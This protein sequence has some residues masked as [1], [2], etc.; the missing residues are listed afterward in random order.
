M[1]TLHTHPQTH[2]ASGSSEAAHCVWHCESTRGTC[3]ELQ[4]PPSPASK[5]TKKFSVVIIHARCYIT[6]IFLIQCVCVCA[7]LF[8]AREEVEQSTHRVFNCFR[9]IHSRLILFSKFTMEFQSCAMNLV[10]MWCGVS[11]TRRRGAYVQFVGTHR[12]D[13]RLSWQDV[14]SFRTKSNALL[15]TTLN[16]TCVCVCSVHCVRRRKQFTFRRQ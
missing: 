13:L 7:I 12:S 10:A 14:R 11:A 1:R 16:L 3:S 15:S 2:C 4:Q 6:Y 8:P 5:K 9:P